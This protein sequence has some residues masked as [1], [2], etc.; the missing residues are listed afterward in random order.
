MPG[1][2]RNVTVASVDTNVC[3]ACGLCSATCR[4]NSI[5]LPDEFSLDDQTGVGMSVVTSIVKHRGGKIDFRSDGGTCWRLEL[6]LSAGI[7]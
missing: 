7:E 2:G 1:R 3:M 5:G 4:S 6:P